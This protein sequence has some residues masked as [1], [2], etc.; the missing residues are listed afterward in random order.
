MRVEV[1]LV[2]LVLAERE[3]LTAPTSGSTRKLDRL[4]HLVPIQEV[5]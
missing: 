3:A 4:L 2:V 5:Q 1:G